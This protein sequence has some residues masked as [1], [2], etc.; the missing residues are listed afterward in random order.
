MPL[1]GGLICWANLR[2]ASTPE[3]VAEAR[4]V[5]RHPLLGPQPKGASCHRKVRPPGRSFASGPFET[6]MGPDRGGLV[7]PRARCARG[8]PL[9]GKAAGAEAVRFTIPYNHVT[10]TATGREHAGRSRVDDSS[11]AAG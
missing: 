11:T 4:G 8:C 7:I 1:S 6:S 3:P 10:V 2:H 9:F 5:T